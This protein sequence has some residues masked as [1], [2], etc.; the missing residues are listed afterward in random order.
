MKAKLAGLQTLR[1]FTIA[2]LMAMLVSIAAMP[3]A[4]HAANFDVNQAND[5]GDADL[6]DNI[7]DSDL[8]TS[9]HQCALRA[10]IEQ[11]NAL[12]GS[13]TINLTVPG[14][15]NLTIG[16][17]LVTSPII[18][19]GNG[20]TIRRTGTGKFRIFLVS[21]TGDLTLNKVTVQDGD[22]LGSG[23]GIFIASEGIVNIHN[24]I[25]SNNTATDPGGGIFNDGYSTLNILNSAIINNTTSSWG[26]GITNSGGTMN[27]ANTTISGNIA[28][29]DGGGIDNAG[30]VLANLTNVTITN[31]IANN[32]GILPGTGGGIFFNYG[33]LN[34]KSSIIAGNFDTPGNIG[35]SFNKPDVG[36]SITS[37]GYNLIGNVGSTSFTSQPGDQVGTGTNPIDPLLGS[38]S[39]QPVYHPLLASSP[40]IDQIPAATHCVFISSGSNPLFS[41]GT[42]INTD[43]RDAVRPMDGDNDGTATCDIGAYEFIPPI[44]LPII[45]VEK[46]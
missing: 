13:D 29:H 44:Y 18:V 4:A 9:G 37:H 12:A 25:I 40:A 24:S 28:N 3:P 26:G 15:Y 43:Q 39:G 38:L 23:G 42:A 11:A 33:T 1:L 21:R 2:I 6:S 31:N 7:C 8:G 19:N 46:E 30:I 5:A 32:D 27:I 35:P 34:V 20:A 16:Q 36:G 22:V 10:A 41:P 45:I 14:P 17:L